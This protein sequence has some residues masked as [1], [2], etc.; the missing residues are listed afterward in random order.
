MSEPWPWQGFAVLVLLVFA[1]GF[2]LVVFAGAGL[3]GPPDGRIGP[4]I[5][6]SPTVVP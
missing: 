5:N 2:V 4:Y 1:I 3:G 6:A